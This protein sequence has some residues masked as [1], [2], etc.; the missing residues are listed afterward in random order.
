MERTR[1]DEPHWLSDMF[2]GNQS[3]EYKISEIQKQNR[4]KYALLRAGKHEHTAIVKANP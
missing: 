1:R 4:H 2:F 3:D